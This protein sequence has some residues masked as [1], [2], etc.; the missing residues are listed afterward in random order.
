MSPMWYCV[1]PADAI[2]VLRADISPAE[3]MVI[4]LAPKAWQA[5]CARF[6]VSRFWLIW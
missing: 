1:V 6:Q 2:S 4:R 3:M 5:V